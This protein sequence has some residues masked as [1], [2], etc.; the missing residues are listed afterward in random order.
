M[1]KEYL[2]RGYLEVEGL[3][4]GRA[5][6]DTGTFSDLSDAAVFVR[7]VQ[8]R[9]GLKIGAPEEVAWRK[10]FVSDRTIGHTFPSGRLTQ[11]RFHLLSLP[12]PHDGLD[13]D[14]DL[15]ICEQAIVPH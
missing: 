7:T 5:W 4:R 13:F 2:R 15:A 10:G 1:N 11:A 6:L 8:G 14:G 9:H 12:N 3:P